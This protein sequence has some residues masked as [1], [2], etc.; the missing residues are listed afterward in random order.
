MQPIVK[1]M[2]HLQGDNDR[3]TT[4]KSYVMYLVVQRKG[5]AKSTPPLKFLV[6]WYSFLYPRLNCAKVHNSLQMLELQI[7]MST[8][9]HV[10]VCSPN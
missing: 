6:A 7:M 2:G 3:E 10:N 9:M 4:Y 1:A 5:I 8:H